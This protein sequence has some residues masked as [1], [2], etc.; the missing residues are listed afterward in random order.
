MAE[1]LLRVARLLERAQHQVGEDA[2][3]GLAR[4]PLGEVLVVARRDLEVLRID[5]LLEARVALAFV[6]EA[7]AHAAG[8]RQRHAQR[9]AEAGGDFLKLHHFFRVR[10][11]VDAVQRG[12]AAALQVRGHCFVG[13]EH[14][15]LDD[16]VRHVALRA[17]DADHAPVLVELDLRLG[18]VEINRASR[19]PPPV[20]YPRQ[21]LHP[22]EVL[23]L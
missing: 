4:Q 23:E 21:L 20:E 11:L 1:I 12:H 2:L 17:R 15:L 7:H 8:R 14:E 3:L 19:L 22:L 18:K 9:I 16:A 5:H 13:R 10:P 6:A